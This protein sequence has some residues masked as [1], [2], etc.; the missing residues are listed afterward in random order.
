M[1][2]V[3]LADGVS[4]RIEKDLKGFL[5]R[6]KW[7]AERGQSKDPNTGKTADRKV[8]LIVVDTCYMVHLDQERHRS[9]KRWLDHSITTFACSIWRRGV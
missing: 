3:V 2:S 9:F 6:G 8:Y 4:E 7:Y 5:G 1:G